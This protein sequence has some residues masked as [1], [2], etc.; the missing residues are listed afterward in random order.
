MNP[1]EARGAA[2]RRWR[3]WTS[4]LLVAALVA[5]VVAPAAGADDEEE[6]QGTQE[7]YVRT[8]DGPKS[9]AEME[10]E[11][12]WSYNAE[13]IFAVSRAVRDSRVAPAGKVPLFILSMPLDLVMLPF[14]AIAGLLGE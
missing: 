4:I 6:R 5:L 9:L 12:G 10:K 13:Y 14:A 8:V 2:G 1:F 3:V 11:P 7:S